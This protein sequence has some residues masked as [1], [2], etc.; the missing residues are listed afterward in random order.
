VYKKRRSC[1]PGSSV[2][3]ISFWELFENKI[4]DIILYYIDSLSKVIPFFTESLLCNHI[5][6]VSFAP[7]ILRGMTVKPVVATPPPP[8]PN[9]RN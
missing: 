9:P 6:Y 4:T 2:F 3:D 8:P 7:G 5:L 1:R